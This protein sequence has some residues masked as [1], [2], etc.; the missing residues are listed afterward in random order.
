MI[1]NCADSSGSP[2]Q[3]KRDEQNIN[4]GGNL[5]NVAT[6]GSSSFKYKSSILGNLAAT[7]VS[8]NAKKIV[9]LKYLSNFFRS[10]EMPLIS[11]KTHL[12]L[13]WSKDFV[14]SA[15][16]DTTFQITRTKLYVPIVTLSTKDNV[17]LTKQSIP[18]QCFTYGKTR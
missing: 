9:P 7:R 5:A 10:L 13:S 15:K 14:I 18:S 11:C 4:A 8:E 3:F 16:T 1:D 12:E 2:Y 17:N 6:T